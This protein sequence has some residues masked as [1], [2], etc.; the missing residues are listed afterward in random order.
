MT[1]LEK[2]S[3]PR[4]KEVRNVIGSETAST[5][6]DHTGKELKKSSGI[7]SPAADGLK[8]SGVYSLASQERMVKE[9]LKMNAKVLTI[10]PCVPADQDHYMDNLRGM[11]LRSAVGM[12]HSLRSDL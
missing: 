2:E 12:T 3:P 10:T 9:N 1:N 5:A 8:I 4:K 11:I 6:V 7:D